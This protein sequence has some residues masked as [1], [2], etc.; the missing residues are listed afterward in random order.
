MPSTDS[1]ADRLNRLFWGLSGATLVVGPPLAKWYDTKFQIHS[2]V[3]MV[4][5][6][7]A[8][9]LIISW[10]VALSLAYMEREPHVWNV[11]FKSV[12]IP[13]TVAAVGQAFQL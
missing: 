1:F 13:G 10:L 11:F 6:M 7:V 8:I 4:E 2:P 12:G 5:Y 9:T 3:P